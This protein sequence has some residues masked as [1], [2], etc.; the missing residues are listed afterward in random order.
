MKLKYTYIVFAC[1]LLG[2][3]LKSNAGGR[4]SQTPPNQSCG[5]GAGC[6]TPQAAGTTTIDSIVVQDKSTGAS[7]TQYSPGQAYRVLLFGKYVGTSNMYKFGY[8]VGTSATNKGTFSG[9]ST[10]ATAAV[11]GGIG[12]WGHTAPKDSF[13]RINAI[14]TTYYFDSCTWTAPA[15]GSGTV[16]LTGYL[17]AVNGNGA[18]SGD[19]VSNIG[20]K[21]LAE[22]S[23]NVTINSPGGGTVCAGVSKTFTAT[24]TNGGTSPTYQWY[25]NGTPVGTGGTAFTTTTLATNDSVWVVMTS[26]ISGI[27]NNPATSNKIKMTVNPTYNNN[28]T[29]A[30][31]KSS[32]CAGDTV[33]F[34]AT[35]NAG[36]TVP[37]Y[38]WYRNQ[39]QVAGPPLSGSNP[40]Y[41]QI[42][43]TAGDSFSC[44][45]SVSNTC[46]NPALDTSNFVKIT[47]NA[48]PVITGQ[49]NDT[50]CA[51][52]SSKATNWQSTMSG[53]T[54]TWTNN[55]PAI[56]LP[57]SGS[58]QIPK[59]KTPDAIAMP[60][61]T[62]TITVRSFAGGCSGAPVTYTIVV[63]RKPTVSVANV[64]PFYCVGDAGNITLTANPTFGT[65]I[66]WTNDN[67]ATGIAASGA[68]G[69]INFTAT[70][71]TPD[72]IISNITATVTQNNGCKKDSVFKVVVYPKATVNTISNVNVCDG[73]TV[74][75][76]NFTSP[77]SLASFAWTN[78][79]TAIGLGASGSGNIS[80]FTAT[81]TSTGDI[82][83]TIT[84]TP[85]YKTCTGTP[86]TFTITVSKVS[87]PSVY[88]ETKDT[89]LCPGE[90]ALFKAFPTNGGSTP[91]YEWYR[92]GVLMSG[93]TND[94]ITVLNVAN[95]DVITCKMTSNS[96][97][98]TTATA[99]SSPYTI[100]TITSVTPTIK[101]SSL[102][103]T[104]CKGQ[105]VLFNSSITYGGTSP[106][107]Q[108]YLNG[109][110]ISGATSDVY[111]SSTFQTGDEVKCIMTSS[112][113]CAIPTTATSNI[114]KLKVFNPVSASLTLTKDKNKI[115][116]D[117]YVTFTAT[118]TGGGL[119]PKVNWKLNGAQ[120][121][122]NKKFITVPISGTYDIVEL[123]VKSSEPCPTPPYPT[124][125]MSVDTVL[126]G[127][128]VNV[129]PDKYI[130]M[131]EGD[132][133]IVKVF[134][135]QPNYKYSWS[136]GSTKDSF[137]S[138]TTTSYTLTVTETGNICPRHYG[139]LTTSINPLPLKPSIRLDNGMI[140]SSTSDRYQWQLNKL[141][142]VGA[143]SQQ[144]KYLINGNYR[145]K[146][147]NNA[148][149]VNYSD[150]LNPAN[151]SI[152][153]T[154]NG[155]IVVF[156]NPS[157]GLFIISS[158]DK[159]IDEIAVYDYTGKLVYGKW[160]KS[161]EKQV[162][163]TN[164]PKGNYLL[165][166]RVDQKYHEQKIELR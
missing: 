128:V 87:A 133:S 159:Q 148:G 50:I 135:G 166:L 92:N 94:T 120:M 156:P 107:Y 29:I 21:T 118:F 14:S 69:F 164:L 108:W 64:K 122:T 4:T 93:S 51:G 101:I 24:P 158:I 59:F 2:I 165:Q 160:I 102:S 84:V 115:C 10:N 30:A 79:N 130:A 55:N 163:L 34:T 149:C 33:I 91:T 42:G 39:V 17:N 32:A 153:N 90:S 138:K 31:N 89:G 60:Q 152:V 22:Y 85:K 105:T 100:K 5:T 103:D 61:I 117:D 143:D 73:A 35:P 98:V 81:N 161:K 95:N 88:I 75:G 65:T 20:I 96:G 27:G 86:S 38:R 141:D 63:R 46:A 139:P 82:A 44:R 36:A 119:N 134:N 1:I 140:I 6:H 16:N 40:T 124:L 71:T 112:F 67:T 137:Y 162:D 62:A 9:T 37:Q 150:E 129:Y 110:A 109:T 77:T 154:T 83:G 80:S 43:L 23:A 54:Y 48:S 113:G 52:D 41:Q 74:S 3:L 53:T 142:I 11:V 97:C 157:D 126:Q 70:N 104:V 72:S 49:I 99:N 151:S 25:K 127:P 125:T 136:N 58:G 155:D 144:Y 18:T 57:A 8:I 106:Q 146:I 47:V 147:T 28:V 15:A 76:I 45:L 131:C 7:V 111:F 26:S 68:N 132:S 123:T 121:N 12:Y 116:S 78:T 13:L 56:G 114:Y 145:V 19:K 66:S